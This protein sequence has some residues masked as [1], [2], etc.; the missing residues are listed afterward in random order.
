[1]SICAARSAFSTDSPS[2][3]GQH[4]VEDDEV[5]AAVGGAEQAV[6]AVA[7]PVRRY[8]PPGSGPWRGRTRFRGRP[9]PAG[10]FGPSAR[11]PM[12][13]RSY[14]CDR[15]SATVF[16]AAS[17][18]R[19]LGHFLRRIVASWRD[20]CVACIL[21]CFA[22]AS[23][24]GRRRGRLALGASSSWPCRDW[25][26]VLST[27]APRRAMRASRGKRSSNCFMASSSPGVAGASAIAPVLSAV[28]ARLNGVHRDGVARALRTLRRARVCDMIAQKTRYA[29]RSLLFLAEEQGGAPVQLG[30]IAETQRVPPKYLELIMLDLKK[31][32][33]VKSARGPK[34]G[35]QA[36]AP[37]GADFL[38]R[39]RPHDGRADRAGVLRERQFL[40]AVRRL[41]GRGDL[42]D[43]PRVRD[44][45]R[46][47]HGG[48]RFNL[49][50]PRGSV[51]G[52][53]GRRRRYSR[54]GCSRAGSMQSDAAAWTSGF[55]LQRA[56]C[57]SLIACSHGKLA[58][59]A[60]RSGSASRIARPRSPSQ[61]RSSIKITPILL[62]PATRRRTCMVR[63]TCRAIKVPSLSTEPTLQRDWLLD[64]VGR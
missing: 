60:P 23:G 11:T 50:R 21:A 63:R 32:G 9:R 13:R 3:T 4:A 37:V 8:G 6:L 2:R 14:A 5:E 52:A 17:S 44:P 1:M 48:A 64:R 58:R 38:R 28:A 61:W 59:R 54:A 46:P 35:Y 22:V 53:A 16:R 45:S 20:A 47:E 27:G 39:S 36:G 33:L 25:C 56:R 55:A 19:A 41:P 12:I 24:D 15:R 62:T 30:R 40:R 51:G 31:A 34:G 7:S 29:L 26:D 43:P 18:C 10:S 57:R 42:R 49:A